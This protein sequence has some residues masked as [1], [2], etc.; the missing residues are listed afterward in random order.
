[1]N[2][3]SVAHHS[4]GKNVEEDRRLVRK[5]GRMGRNLVEVVALGR[6]WDLACKVLA[7]DARTCTWR[8]SGKQG[9]SGKG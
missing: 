3:S 4:V 7:V 1:M 5:M 8:R 6:A 9:N 2:G